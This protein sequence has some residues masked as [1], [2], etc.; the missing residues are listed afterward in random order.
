[1]SSNIIDLYGN[2][3]A[4]IKG[5]RKV[6]FAINQ[7][8]GC[9]YAVVHAPDWLWPNGRNS[10]SLLEQLATNKRRFINN[11]SVFREIEGGFDRLA[12]DV[13]DRM[14]EKAIVVNDTLVSLR[15]VVEAKCSPGHAHS[16]GSRLTAKI[17]ASLLGWDFVDAAD[18]VHFENDALDLKTTRERIAQRL[19]GQKTVLSTGY[20]T[21][22]STGEIVCFPDTF[23]ADMRDII[24]GC[25]RAERQRRRVA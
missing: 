7:W 10:P 18:V 22:T 14:P 12:T 9:E 3:V 17:V 13:F 2:Q 25:L 19:A 16:Y 21:R 11:D 15:K 5:L 1:M 23:Q 8:T 4:D 6:I 24:E 20:G